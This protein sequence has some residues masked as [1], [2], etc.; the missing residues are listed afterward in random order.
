MITGTRYILFH[1]DDTLNDEVIFQKKRSMQATNV[2]PGT[3][4]IK[5]LEWTRFCRQKLHWTVDNYFSYII[6]SDKTKIEL[7][8]RN[9]I[10]VWRK[11]DEDV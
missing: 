7:G 5:Y 10:Y 9:N 3:L 4:T 11:S 1:H 8:Y 6:F 2:F